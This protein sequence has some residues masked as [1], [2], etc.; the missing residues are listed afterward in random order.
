MAFFTVRLELHG[1][2][3]AQTARVD[4]EMRTA[5]FV[6]TITSDQGETFQL[7]SGEYSFEHATLTCPQVMQLAKQIGERVKPG[8]WVLVTQAT[9]RAWD[10]VKL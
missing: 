8:C 1:A 10:T 9:I 6:R 4:V 7:P 5:G 2:T 3:A